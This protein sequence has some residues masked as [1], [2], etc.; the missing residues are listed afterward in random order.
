MKT[1][2][3]IMVLLLGLLGL[4]KCLLGLIMIVHVKDM[5][6]VAG[7]AA[8]LAVIGYAVKIVLDETRRKK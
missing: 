1:M 3:R 5:F 8:G 6:G 4:F 7:L 2:T